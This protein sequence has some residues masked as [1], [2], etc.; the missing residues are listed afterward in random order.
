MQRQLPGKSDK[1][2]PHGRLGRF[3]R[4]WPAVAA[5]RGQRKLSAVRRFNI[6]L[7]RE[8]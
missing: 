4:S 2:L 8:E 7:R 6:E 1:F 5:N 3:T